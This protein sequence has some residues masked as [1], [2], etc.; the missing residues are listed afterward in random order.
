M[1]Y[2]KAFE[3]L[4]DRINKRK[5]VGHWSECQY[6]KYWSINEMTKPCCN[7]TWADREYEPEW[8]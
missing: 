6:C 8:E 7:C 5:K 3:E 4:I 2:K 1:D